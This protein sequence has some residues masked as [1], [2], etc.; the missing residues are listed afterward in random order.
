MNG[1]SFT[2][3][4][5][6]LP[7]RTFLKGL[8]ASMALPMLDAMMPENAIGAASRTASKLPRRMA[9]VYVPNGVRMDQWTPQAVGARYELPYILKPLQPFQRDIQ[10]LS[11]LTHDKARANGDGPG[12]HAR[13]NA[14]FLT[15]MQAYKTAGSD[16]K[17]GV[18]IDQVAARVIGDQTRLPSLELS[19]DKGR[20]AGNCDSGY[21]CA[22]QYSISWRGDATPMPPQVN[23]RL[24]FERL[25]SDGATEVDSETKAR[26]K[27]YQKSIL[28]FVMT[29]AK[30]LQGKLGATD[31]RKVDEYLTS[32][33][34]LEQR[35]E[36]ADKEGPAR[37]KYEKPAG[38]PSDLQTHTRLM[39]DMMA[40]AFQTD[41]TRIS[42]F[43]IAHDGSN[44]SYPMVNVNEGHHTLSHHQNNED[45]LQKIA[46]INRFHCLQ[47][48]YFLN[49]LKTIKEG[50]GNLLDNSMIVYGSGISD[51]N[52]HN[53]ENLPIILAGRGG[54]TVKSG[55]HVKYAKE[56]PMCDLLLSLTDRMGVRL[57]RFGDSKGRL[58]IA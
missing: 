47:F 1:P 34:E 45:K 42:T 58:R 49:K 13:A 7:R 3:N 28:D 6:L 38:V 52:R 41:T 36:R 8:G 14:T 27:E 35:M 9:F 19:C 51:G 50:E 5:W 33:R 4:K 11:G 12:D 25:F 10:V 16:I 48:A 24:V 31:R 53:N 26:R 40:L 17:I 15:G 46:R 32:V 57:A 54:G 30:R 55:L 37:P 21:S 44:R 29:D 43:M 56:T 23:P 22:Y 18:S 2:T 39:F 20:K